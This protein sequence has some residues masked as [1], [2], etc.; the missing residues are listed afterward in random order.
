MQDQK[1][2]Q[3]TATNMSL[4]FVLSL[5]SFLVFYLIIFFKYFIVSFQLVTKS[6]QKQSCH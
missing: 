4:S 6:L 5:K 3:K 2:N 1:R